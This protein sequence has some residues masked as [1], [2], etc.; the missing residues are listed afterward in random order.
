[1][2]HSFI[3]YCSSDVWSGASSKSE[4]SESLAFLSRFPAPKSQGR[5]AGLVTP[6]NALIVCPRVLAPSTPCRL[7]TAGLVPAGVLTPG[8][9][10][11]RGPWCSLGHLTTSLQLTPAPAPVP[12]QASRPPVG[13][14]PPPRLEAGG[15][16]L[17]PGSLLK[18]PFPHADE[19]AFMGALII[20]EVV[21]ELLGKG[22]SGAKVLLL[23]GSR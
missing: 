10:L 5:E 17:C 22:L 21:R 12:G 23:A 15:L 14:P 2:C 1:M 7:S 11:G 16:A 9:F 19:Y 18:P 4:K 8:C 3:P 13:T 20:Q 6:S